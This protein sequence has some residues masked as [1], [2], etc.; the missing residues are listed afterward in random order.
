MSRQGLSTA[1]SL[2]HH[3]VSLP[4][5]CSSGHLQEGGETWE[6]EYRCDPSLAA[7]QGLC[8]TGQAK[9]CLLSLILIPALFYSSSTET[10]HLHFI[11]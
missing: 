6:W 10:L 2:C 1:L 3:S 8:G 9:I 11:T 4:V 5:L 7:L